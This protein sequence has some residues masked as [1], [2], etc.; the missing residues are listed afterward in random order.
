MKNK[1]NIIDF[2]TFY[3]VK[4]FSPPKICFI[5][6]ALPLTFPFVINLLTVQKGC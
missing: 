5:I 1:I 4:F 3:S 6:P 2:K